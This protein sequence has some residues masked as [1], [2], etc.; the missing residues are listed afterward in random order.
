MAGHEILYNCK[1]PTVW[2]SIFALYGDVV[3]AKA[4]ASKGKKAGKLTALDKWYQEELPEAICSRKEK[5]L[6]HTEL[7]Q[8][9]EWKLTRGKFRPTLQQMVMSN[10]RDSVEACTCK[11]FK[12]LPD[13]SAAITELSKLKAVGPATASAV[14]VAGAPQ[15]AAFMAD[16]AVESIPGLVPIKYTLKHY[17]LYLQK[18]RECATQLNSNDSVKDW[19]PHRIE[20]CLW[21]WAVGQQVNPLLLK[22]VMLHQSKTVDKEKATTARPV[23]RQKTQ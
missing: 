5:F 15:E 23:K 3:E 1:N 11:A 8:L 19:T 14:L 21:T 2:R 13:V 20:Q 16:E 6:T 7:V 12:L 22:G 4:M 9:M 18:V 10:S 17:I